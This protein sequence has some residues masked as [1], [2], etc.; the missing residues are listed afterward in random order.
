M[1][2]LLNKYKDIFLS[3][4]KQKLN[5][6]QY[7]RSISTKKMKTKKDSMLFSSA[8]IVQKERLVF[9]LNAGFCKSRIV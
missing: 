5:C 3:I 8:L 7:I 4:I 6:R 2:A 1:I 9:V